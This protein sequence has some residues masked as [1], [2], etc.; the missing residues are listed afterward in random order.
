ML[1]G[2]CSAWRI[3]P[4]TVEGSPT[5]TVLEEVWRHGE[6]NNRVPAIQIT[7]GILAEPSCDL[8]N[9]KES[10]GDNHYLQVA[11]RIITVKAWKRRDTPRITDQFQKV[12]NVLEMTKLSSLVLQQ[13]RKTEGFF[14]FAKKRIFLPPT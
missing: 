7:H 5:Q 9:I 8:C 13:R 3:L 12:Q 11:A 1:E 6:G 14:T 2:A 10:K 4:Q